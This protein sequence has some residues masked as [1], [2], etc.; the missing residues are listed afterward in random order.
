MSTQVE[1]QNYK[2]TE[3]IIWGFSQLEEG[4]ASQTQILTGK[5]KVYE[6]KN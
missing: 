3:L 6:K 5:K 2:G 1:I 4:A